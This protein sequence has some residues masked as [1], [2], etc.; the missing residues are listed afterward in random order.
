MRR[1]GIRHTMHFRT[2]KVGRP[3]IHPGDDGTP[4]LGRAEAA[5][6]LGIHPN[7]LDRHRKRH[8]ALLGKRIIY[9]VQV[10]YSYEEL[11]H[12]RDTYLTPVPREAVAAPVPK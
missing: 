3:G 2:G 8:P 10:V 4:Y 11:D 12:F 9:G 1:T 7:T 6:Y 5:A